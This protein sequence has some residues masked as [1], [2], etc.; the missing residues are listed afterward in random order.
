MDATPLLQSLIGDVN[1]LLI[2]RVVE[3]NCFT[4]SGSWTKSNET[5]SN[6]TKANETK[7]N[8]TA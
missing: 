1:L 5:K 2:Q 7:A 3:S 6:E 8:E 4:Q